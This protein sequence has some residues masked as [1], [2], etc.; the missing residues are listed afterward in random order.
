M[1]L[2]GKGMHDFVIDEAELGYRTAYR[3]VVSEML[4]N[5]NN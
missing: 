2:Y 3:G 4:F 5:S 1:G